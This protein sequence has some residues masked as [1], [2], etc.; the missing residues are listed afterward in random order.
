VKTATAADYLH[1][2]TLLRLIAVLALVL[3]AHLPSLPSWEIALVVAGLG[4]RLLT[5]LR[6]W[7]LPPGWLRSTLALLLFAGIYASYGRI[8]GQQPGTALIVAMAVLKLLEMRSRRDVMVTVFLMYFILL[9]HFLNSQE[10]WT[11]G[12]L[13]VCA[14]AITALLVDVTH[15][16][17]PLALTATLR[18]GG[19]LVA[20]SLPLMVVF[21]ILFPRLPGP[22]WGLPA[23]AGAGLTGMSNEMAPGDI[24]NLILSEEVVFRVRFIDRVPQPRERYW[25]GPVFDHFDGRAWKPS[26]LSQSIR[27][28]DA[29][30]RNPAI[31]YEVMM[32]PHRGPWLFALDLPDPRSLPPRTFIASEYQLLQ[33][34]D[35]IEQQLYTLVSFPRYRLQPNLPDIRRRINLNLPREFNPRSVAL[36]RQ[37]R[38]QYASDDEIIR[39]ALQM[40]RNEPFVYTLQ[41][42]TVGLHSVD[43]FLFRTRR[44]FCEHYSSAFTVLMRA[45]GIPARVVTGYQGAEHNEIGD[46]FVVR[47]SD[48]HA[49]SEVWLEE[50]GWVR[51]DPTAAVAPNRIESGLSEAMSAEDGLPDFL[52]RRGRGWLDV[53]LSARWDWLNSQWDR[54]ILAYGPELQQEFLRHFGI[55]DWGGMILA[56]TIIGTLMLSGIGLMLLREFAPARNEDVALRLW[57]RMQ[58]RLRRLQLEQRPDEGPRDFVSRVAAQ[59]PQLAGPLGRVLENYLRLR[60]LEDAS[61]EAQKGLAEAIKALPR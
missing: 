39:A 25:R 16:G 13:V 5:A 29:E 47:Q 14:V 56:L 46:Y 51:V 60:Y 3:S 17:R 33:G 32:E 48:A 45:A 28:P 20:S 41:P 30:L 11:I 61:P 42:P 52:D 2:V 18:L 19:R 59:H 6:Q 38:E 4:W 15:R 10:I 40:F 55:K 31:T 12:Y 22:L 23:D 27:A 44:G 8:N 21:F 9:T 7:P 50:Q 1:H 57:H 26:A 34:R 49:W 37:W 54:W 58:K 36:A 53:D 35:Q 43:D 24:A